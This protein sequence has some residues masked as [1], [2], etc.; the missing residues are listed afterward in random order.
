[1]SLSGPSCRVL[2]PA[3]SPTGLFRS[4]GSE[5]EAHWRAEEDRRAEALPSE[6]SRVARAGAACRDM[7]QRSSQ[8]S[9]LAAEDR[10]EEAALVFPAHLKLGDVGRFLHMG[11]LELIQ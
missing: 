7:P 3:I 11:L 10:A 2:P 6:V 5:G 9:M 8:D 4:L 1:M